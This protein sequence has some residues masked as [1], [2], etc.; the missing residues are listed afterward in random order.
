LHLVVGLV[1]PGCLALAW[2]QVTRALSGNTLS[3]V[4]VFEWPIFAGY[5]LFMWWKLMH[6]FK[7]EPTTAG[8]GLA[9][10]L[11]V[12]ELG[13]PAFPPPTS[14]E[15]R[16]AGG[17]PTATDGGPAVEELSPWG[18]C[19]E[20]APDGYDEDEELAAYNEYLAALNAGDDRSRRRGGRTPGS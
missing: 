14:C 19:A 3:W 9:E 12:G 4:Y 20:R 10:D 6:E 18:R 16:D 11:S 2:W 8:P 7:R 5:A 17:P 13:T 15:K 1:V